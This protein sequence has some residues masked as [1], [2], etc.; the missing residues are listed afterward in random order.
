M[1]KLIDRN[2][3][4][5]AVSLAQLDAMIRVYGSREAIL[6]AAGF[7]SADYTR[8]AAAIDLLTR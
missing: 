6:R 8:L 1:M 5:V 4:H 2:P 7:A 3:H